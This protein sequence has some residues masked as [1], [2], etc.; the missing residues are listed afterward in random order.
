MSGTAFSYVIARP[1]DENDPTNLC[2]YAY[3][4]EVQSGTMDSAKNLL[5]YVHMMS[6]DKRYSI[7]RVNFEKI[8]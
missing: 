6:P 4:S 3:G 8:E 7:Y 5:E 2:I 1:W